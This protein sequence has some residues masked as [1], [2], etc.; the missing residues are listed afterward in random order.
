M[1]FNPLFK[2]TFIGHRSKLIPLFWTSSDVCSGLALFMLV[3]A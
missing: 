1:A 2:E 3:G